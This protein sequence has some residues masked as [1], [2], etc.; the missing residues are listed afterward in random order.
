[1]NEEHISEIWMLFKEYLDRKQTDIVAEKYIDMLAD[2]GVSD[3]VFKETLGHDATLDA[4]IG[5]FL[6]INTDYDSDDW[7]D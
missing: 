3:E 5:Y 4:A 6:D 2:H 7:E 1:M